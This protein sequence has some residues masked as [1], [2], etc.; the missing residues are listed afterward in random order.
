MYKLLEKFNAFDN[1][2]PYLMN[3]SCLLQVYV[4]VSPGWSGKVQGLCGNYNQDKM[5][6]FISQNGIRQE[7][8]YPFANSWK[9][10]ESC[11]DVVKSIETPCEKHPLRKSFAET[12]CS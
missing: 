2:N 12:M 9:L 10:M 6:D 11:P 8:A 1:R 4:R 3:N 7:T 5:D